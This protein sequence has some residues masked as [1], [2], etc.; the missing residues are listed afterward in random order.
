MDRGE[1]NKTRKKHLPALANCWLLHLLLSDSA[2]GST[3]L[4]GRGRGQVL[5]RARVCGSN[6][7]SCSSA[8]ASIGTP[9]LDRPS[10]PPRGDPGQGE[11]NESISEARSR[12]PEDFVYDVMHDFAF[13]RY[14]V[15]CEFS[16][17]GQYHR[18]AM[19]THNS[20][21]PI[22]LSQNNIFVLTFRLQHTH[23]HTYFCLSNL[24]ALLR[25]G[26]NTLVL[27]FSIIFII[28]AWRT[29]DFKLLF[30]FHRSLILNLITY[31][32]GNNNFTIVRTIFIQNKFSFLLI[33]KER[34]LS[35][36]GR[37]IIIRFQSITASL[38]ADVRR[39]PR[40]RKPDTLRSHSHHI[41]RDHFT[42]SKRDT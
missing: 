26:K 23:T 32:S 18:I 16:H 39:A 27:I 24:S 22:F 31:F 9:S 12:V 10:R 33:W 15:K 28:F 30:T 40:K 35:W 11:P 8:R 3:K 25:E 36:N 21:V 6:V 1:V 13:A 2:S 38:L 7:P 4:S 5:E 19:F 41:H 14:D 42:V 34:E 20:L 29:R 37:R 17:V